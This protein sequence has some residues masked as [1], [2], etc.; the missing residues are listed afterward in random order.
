MAS[1]RAAATPESS[2]LSRVLVAALAL[3]ALVMAALAVRTVLE[4]GADDPPLAA[5]PTLLATP[6]LAP[7]V[8]VVAPALALDDARTAVSTRDASLDESA[9][10]PP[11]NAPRVEG[12]TRRRLAR[13][14]VSGAHAGT[15]DSSD[16]VA[17]LNSRSDA[18]ARCWPP[19][20]PAPAENRGRDFLVT[21]APDGSV[22]GARP[23][24]GSE[25]PRRFASCVVDAL[26]QT[27][28]PG[29]SPTA[30]TTIIV[31]LGVEPPGTLMSPYE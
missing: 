28:F 30:P 14:W 10:V 26:E 5:S 25:E 17:V 8:P 27:S 6:T 2:V 1:R 31:F 7:T 16:I 20:V 18:F 4:T 12:R 11:T 22:R 23:R 24:P 13:V 29:I 19:G 15:L 3:A 9:S 21:I